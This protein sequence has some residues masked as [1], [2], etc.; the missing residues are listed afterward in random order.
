M[1]RLSHELWVNIFFWKWRDD[2]LVLVRYTVDEVRGLVSDAK[3]RLVVTDEGTIG[4]AVAACQG[5][6]VDFLV[7]RSDGNDGI[8]FQAM[9]G[10]MAV[11]TMFFSIKLLM[12]SNNNVAVRGR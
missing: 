9:R 11:L 12:T 6:Q 10:M 8:S 2:G 1:R 4:K 7:K 3:A 5:L